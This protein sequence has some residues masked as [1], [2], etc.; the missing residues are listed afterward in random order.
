M[1]FQWDADLSELPAGG[2]VRVG[3]AEAPDHCAP[4]AGEPV[5]FMVLVLG[6]PGGAAADASHLLGGVD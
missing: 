4:G 6:L 2:W 3:G 5:V 1:I